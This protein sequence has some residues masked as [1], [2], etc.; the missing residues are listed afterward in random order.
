M[1]T[2]KNEAIVQMATEMADALEAGNPVT[3]TAR[4]SLPRFIAMVRPVDAALADRLEV[5]A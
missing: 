4:E 1:N 5:F 3:S 2:N